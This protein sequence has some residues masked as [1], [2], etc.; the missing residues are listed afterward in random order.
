MTYQKPGDVRAHGLNIFWWQDREPFPSIVSRCREYSGWVPGTTKIIRNSHGFLEETL[1]NIFGWNWGKHHI[2]GW[3]CGNQ[4]WEIKLQ[5]NHSNYPSVIKH[6]NGR[7]PNNR[8]RFLAGSIIYPW[9]IFC[10]TICDSRTIADTCFGLVHSMEFINLGWNLQPF[11]H[12]FPN[13]NH[14]SRLRSQWGRYHLPRFNGFFWISIAS[15]RSFT[16]T[17]TLPA[18]KC[19]AAVWINS[20]RTSCEIDVN[21]NQ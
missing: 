3:K 12:N 17:F 5:T 1:H 4:L 8:W 16:Q 15:L 14:H 20:T 2:S 11:R 10:Q 7:S 18:S 13:P 21:K 6:G 9:E 19:S